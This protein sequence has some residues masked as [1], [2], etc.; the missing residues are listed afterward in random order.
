VQQGCD[1]QAA[2][3]DVLDD[4]RVQGRSLALLCCRFRQ[5]GRL[6][7]IHGRQQAER[8]MAAGQ[9]RLAAICSSAATIIRIE[10]EI[11]AVVVPGPGT[12]AQVLELAERCV[13]HCRPVEPNPDG[14][15]LLL[16]VAIGAALACPTR[17]DSSADVLSQAQLARLE[18]ESRPG[19][20]LVL[21]DPGSQQLAEHRYQ[22]ESALHLALQKD[23]LLAYLQPIVNLRDGTAIG[24][25]CLARW[26]QP[27]GTVATP[28]EFLS[29]GHD[30]GITADIDLQ[31]IAASLA[32]A[33]DLAQAAGPQ[34]SLILSANISAQ[35]IES[36]RQVEALLA[37]IQSTPRPPTVR[38]Q[39]ELLEESL[40]NAVC[41]LD[42][43]LEWLAEQGV[44]IAIDD[45][46]TGYSSLSRLHDLAINTIKVDRSFI[47]RIDATSKP[48][49]H[50]LQTLVAIS[51]DLQMSLTAE[52]IETQAQR[53]WLLDRGVDHGQG[54]L[55][56]EPL[57][58]EQ[59]I[60]YLKKQR[61]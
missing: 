38:L 61:Y 11:L 49:N 4:H 28:A 57:S 23:E 59:A 34:R 12:E 41:E 55:F 52:G 53:Q 9:R 13:S 51:H 16:S 19:H 30:S 31:V 58:L 24:F 3:L 15:P 60:D 21:A 26:P 45:F 43:L 7:A 33:A 18:A 47:R 37:L 25:E 29:H 20:Q 44:L 17:P 6:A 2:L 1:D 56:S 32:A 50:L 27:C 5:Y 14:P 48:S 35:L 40:N 10:P 54:F 39:L 36:P 46:G 22:R 8:L 42:A